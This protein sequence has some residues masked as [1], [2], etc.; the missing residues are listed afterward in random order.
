MSKMKMK[1]KAPKE[2]PICQS[3]QHSYENDRIE[4]ERHNGQ[5]IIHIESEFTCLECD[6]IFYYHTRY[7]LGTLISESVN[8]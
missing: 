1:R 3:K 7:E 4:F 6:E 8:T 2:C 5:D